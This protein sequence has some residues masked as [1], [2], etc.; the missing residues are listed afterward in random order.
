MTVETPR[1]DDVM[2]AFHRIRYDVRGP[3]GFRRLAFYQVGADEYLWYPFG[4]IARGNIRGLAEEW[5]P[6]LGGRRHSRVGIPCEGPVPWFSLHES[7]NQDAKGGA[8]ANRGLIVRSWKARLGGRP[9]D[10]PHVSVFGTE[11]GVPSASLELSPPPGVERLEAGDFVEAELEMAIVPVAGDDYYGPNEGLRRALAE[12]G[13][14]WR[15]VLREA[16]GNAL[17][18]RAL[19]GRVRRA[20]PIEVEVGEDGEAE[21]DVSGGV[22]YVPVTFAG[23]AG[24]DAHRLER[25]VGGRPEPVDQS[26]HGGDFWQADRDPEAGTWSR[27]YNVALDAGG[28]GGERT[29]RLRL[30]IPR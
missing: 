30:A 17:E 22:G 25:I 19:R 26:V 11:S 28:D 27:T 23:L 5:K 3:T 29:I 1:A 9:A 21:I 14:T 6:E 18:V 20:Y 2:R 12:G 10:V 15:P 13:N 16:A 24:P 7:V 8:W 4:K